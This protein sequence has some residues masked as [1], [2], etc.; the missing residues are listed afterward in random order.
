MFVTDEDREAIA[1]VREHGGLDYVKS[2]WNERVPRDRYVRMRQRLL[3]HIAECETALGRRREIISELSHRVS[4]LTCENAELRRRAMPEGME[5]LVEA[6]PK[7]EDDAPLKF[8]DMALIDGHADMVEAIQLWIHGRPVICGDG[9]SQQ[10]DKGERVKRPAVPAADG[11]PLEL[12]QTVWDTDA[13]TDTPLTVV[14][15]SSDMVRCEYTW[16]DG[17]TYRP[18]YQPDQLTHTKPEPI[19]TWE[20]LEED[21]SKSY[22]EYWGCVDVICNRCPAEIDGKRPHER[23]DACSHNC[24]LAMRHDIVRRAKALAERERGE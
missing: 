1:W 20:R 18:C 11:E 23:F 3:G 9:G 22:T 10:L 17:K 16:K 12:G 8:G 15:V 21:L 5:W 4:D 2:E 7:F 19:D 14:E 24:I 6:W 13:E